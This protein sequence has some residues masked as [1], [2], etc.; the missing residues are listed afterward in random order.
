MYCRAISYNFFFWRAGK[1]PSSRTHLF[2][3]QAEILLCSSQDDQSWLSFISH[4]SVSRASNGAHW[5]LGLIAI[6]L[7]ISWDTWAEAEWVRAVIRVWAWSSRVIRSR[8]WSILTRKTPRLNT[9]FISNEICIGP[10]P[11]PREIRPRSYAFPPTTA[12]PGDLKCKR[13]R[14]SFP[15]LLV[16]C[17]DATTSSCL[18]C[19]RRLQKVV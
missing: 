17:S 7:F 15:F 8:A 12:G 3:F 4:A 13:C 5:K 11:Y 1:N 9:D 10:T 14:D 19:K 18:F 2:A 16:S 6:Q